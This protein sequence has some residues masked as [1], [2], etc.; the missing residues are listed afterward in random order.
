MELES[1]L[2]ADMQ[3]GLSVQIDETFEKILTYA[4]VDTQLGQMLAVSDENY[5]YLLEF[6]EKRVLIRELKKLMTSL[7]SNMMPGRNK[8]II[9]IER[10][11]KSYF[12][13]KLLDFKTPLKL[14][15]TPFQKKA[16]KA[17]MRVP[18]GS[19]RSYREQAYALGNDMAFRAVANANGANQLSVIIPCHR[20]INT[21]GKLG[22]Y[23]GGL[24]RKQ[25]LLDHEKK[26]RKA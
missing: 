24:D 25:W 1:T 22:G 21:S 13:G 23:A 10:E 17:L 6:T 4:W 7:K 26:H 16:W 3:K 9:L 8:P 15:G 5:L 20:I 11:L 18:Y 14:I 2:I 19:T 12:S